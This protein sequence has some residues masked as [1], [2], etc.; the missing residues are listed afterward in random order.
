MIA[1]KVSVN[2]VCSRFYGSAECH[3]VECRGAVC[4]MQAIMDEL[5]LT[6]QNLGLVFRCRGGHSVPH[7][8]APRH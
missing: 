7:Q 8:S 5:W 6:G 2:H 3:N 4:C 1:L